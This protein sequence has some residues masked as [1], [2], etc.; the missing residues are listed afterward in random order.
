MQKIRK[1]PNHFGFTLVEIMAVVAIIGLT[2]A[3]SIPNFL[4]MKMN[5]NE[6]AAQNNLK[7]LYNVLEDYHFVNGRYP[8]DPSEV[9]NFVTLYYGKHSVISNPDPSGNSWTFQGY[10]YQYVV[11]GSGQ[12]QWTAQPEEPFVTGTHVL[13]MD[14][15]GELT[16]SELHA[17]TVIPNFTHDLSGEKP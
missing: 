4:R 3:M 1:R 7:E 15:G 10:R 2:T 11:D 12:W 14:M 17:R 6:E 16:S 8:T 5:A 13:A 9:T